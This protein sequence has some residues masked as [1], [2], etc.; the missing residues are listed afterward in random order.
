MRTPNAT[1]VTGIEILA[2]AV[3]WTSSQE[4]ASPFVCSGH[5]SVRPQKTIRMPHITAYSLSHVNV[6]LFDTFYYVS[7]CICKNKITRFCIFILESTENGMILSEVVHVGSRLSASLTGDVGVFC[8]E[9]SGPSPERARG[10][11]SSSRAW[12]S[13]AGFHPSPCRSP[14]M[15]PCSVSDVSHFIQK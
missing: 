3:V 4:A 8:A 10:A 5:I 9:G 12:G 15:R 13:A 1:Y 2:C 7:V 6:F 14:A 11:P